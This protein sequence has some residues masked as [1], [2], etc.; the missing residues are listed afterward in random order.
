MSAVVFIRAISMDGLISAG[1][2]YKVTYRSNSGAF[3]FLNP[4]G[5]K[6]AI[7]AKRRIVTYMKQNFDHWMRFANDSKGLGLTQDEL[8]FVAATIKTNRWMNATLSG[9]FRDK[10]GF[11]NCE[12]AGALK[13]NLS[14]RVGG[15]L[16]IGPAR[17]FGPREP[18][19][20][21]PVPTTP[22]P[23]RIA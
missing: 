9:E 23:A 21:V 8:W 13:V 20:D 1:V 19:E 14:M 12:L 6:R 3:L 2:G 22:D 18:T 4:P 10:E 17:N 7:T 16:L 15:N 11:V 5:I